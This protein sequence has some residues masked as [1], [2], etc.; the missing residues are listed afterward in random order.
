[1]S[2]E[3]P[4]DAGS[5]V[6]AITLPSSHFLPEQSYVINSAGETLSGHNIKFNFSDV[7]PA[8]MLRRVIDFQPF[9]DSVG[10][11]GR[12]CLVQGG[13]SVGVEVVHNKNN[14]V[15]VGIADIHQI[16]NLRSPVKGRTVLPNAYV[17]YANVRFHKYKYAAGDICSERLVNSLIFR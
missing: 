8:A 5:M 9:G 13:K 3:V 16:F 4:M 15:T 10:F 6:V 2:S 11:R 1:M 17:P 14:S 12:K 7:Q